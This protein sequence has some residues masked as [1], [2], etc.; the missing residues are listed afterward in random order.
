MVTFRPLP[1][2]DLVVETAPDT[3]DADRWFSDRIAEEA[4]AIRARTGRPPLIALSGGSTPGP[5]YEALARDQANLVQ[6]AFWCQTDERDVPPDHPDS[7]QGLIRR[8]LFRTGPDTEIP[9]FLAV[10]LPTAAPEATGRRYAARLAAHLA[11]T[12]ASGIDLVLLG[13]GN[14]GHTASLFPDADWRFATAAPFRAI[15]VPHLGGFRYTLT[16]PSLIGACRRIF[17]ARGSSKSSVIYRIIHD[18]EG[19]YPAGVVSQC[20]ATLWLL[21]EAAAANLPR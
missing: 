11:R 4:A 2:I 7:N 5:V 8:T 17:L 12:G 9:H 18:T 16:L 6:T 20:P 13:I 3:P 1:G 15:R 19:A 21:D 14:D 10:P